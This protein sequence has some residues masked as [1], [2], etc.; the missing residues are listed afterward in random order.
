MTINNT[1]IQTSLDALAVGRTSSNPFVIVFE[2]RNPGVTDIQYP[3]QKLWLNTT[4]NE[5]FLLKN[6]TTSAGILSAN[7]I[8]FAGDSILESLTGDT[9][10]NPVFPNASNNINTFGTAN[11]ITVT[12]DAANNTLTWS[13]T[14]GTAA[15]KFD[16][17]AHTA[18]GTDPVV[19]SNAGVVTITGAQVASA[20]IGANVI[21]T[22]SLAANTFTIEI[23]RSTNNA[24]TN[25]TL[26][27]VCHFKSADFNVDSNGFV[28]LTGSAGFDWNI[29]SINT[30]M[31]VNN[32]YICVSPGGALTMALPSTASSTLGDIIEV[33]LDGAT[34][35]QITQAAGQS[36]RV[37][38]SQT[39]VGVGG[40][41]TTTGTGDSIRLVYQATGR[42]NATP[43]PN[44][45]LTV[46]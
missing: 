23:Q 36:I 17:D 26:N 31:L 30:A 6:F 5:V 39:T 22:D 10:T 3:I 12:G 40:S 35:W 13:L 19:P 9:G 45:N 34:S 32:G 1:T 42:W 4:T 46:V 38:G 21:R 7:W 18:P 16:I 14:N 20:T 11:Q 37:S 25:S 8:H 33:V 41:I 15:A 43:S 29:V 27:G 24:T 28:S 2:D 44:G